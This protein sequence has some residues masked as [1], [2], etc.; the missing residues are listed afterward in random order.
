MET[1]KLTKEIN[2]ILHPRVALIAYASREGESFFV[3]A[4]EIDEKV[5]WAKVCP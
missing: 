5:K 1:N 2:D 4:R 3:E